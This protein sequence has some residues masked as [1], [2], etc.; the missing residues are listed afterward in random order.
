MKPHNIEIVNYQS[1]VGHDTCVEVISSHTT[2]DFNQQ[3]EDK[4]DDGWRIIQ[5]IN[6]IPIHA[7][8]GSILY[9]CVVAKPR[10]T[11]G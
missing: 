10:H 7:K 1:G 5:G 9:T 2:G 8:V 6:A 3:L 4:L 11:Y